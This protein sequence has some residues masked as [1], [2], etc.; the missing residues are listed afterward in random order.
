MSVKERLLK[1]IEYKNLNKNKFEKICGLG[2]GYVSNISKSL[3]E[4]GHEKISN[5]FPEL[6][7]IWL[8]YGEGEM[9]KQQEK[10]K[11]I[12]EFSPVVRNDD[13]VVMSRE[14]FD[15]IVSQQNTLRSQQAT[16]EAMQEER[17]KTTALQESNATCADVKKVG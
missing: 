4:S 13:Q 14:V 17:K 2:V 6:N 15:L 8:L 7:M 12:S 3:G 16:I 10:E 5:K 9:L 11:I 1:Y